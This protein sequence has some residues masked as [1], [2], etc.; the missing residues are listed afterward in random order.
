MATHSSSSTVPSNNT[1]ANFRSWINFVHDMMI[2]AG[3]VQT[4]DTG[5]IN[6]ATVTAPGAANT[7]QG[8]AIY[9]MD[10]AL[11]AT[12]P[13]LL[14]WGFGSAGAADRP[15]LWFMVGTHSDGAGNFIDP[16]DEDRVAWLLDQYSQSTPALAKGTANTSAKLSFGSGDEARVV[17]ILFEATA[18]AVD[19]ASAG[20]TVVPQIQFNDWQNNDHTMLFS[21]ERARD[22]NGDYV[23]SHVALI[24]TS[25]T[26]LPNRH[27]YIEAEHG[28]V[29]LSP[30]TSMSHGLGF[31]PATTVA[32]AVITYGD[33]GPPLEGGK[34]YEPES[35]DLVAPAT[36]PIHFMRNTFP[37]PPGINLQ[38]SRWSR[39]QFDAWPPPDHSNPPDPSPTPVTYVSGT[40]IAI[41]PYGVPRT[42]RTVAGLRAP[43]ETSATSGD[44]TV[45][46]Y[47]LYE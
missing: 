25:T 38:V 11:A 42:Y 23:G 16:N 30:L 37:V 40:T 9:A 36:P 14:K 3:W 27:A 46:V 17:F 47:I 22:W 31:G 44:P 45:W 1:D 15:G 19:S 18:T 28:H 2:A 33:S 7:K 41:S 43:L 39:F 20:G 5:Q 34:A 35:L 13:I 26:A 21:I 24:W 29:L 12:Y 4:A 10:D 32:P 6:F 8:Y